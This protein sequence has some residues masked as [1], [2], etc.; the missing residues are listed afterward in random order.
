M[1][2]ARSAEHRLSS[3]K[4]CSIGSNKTK[5]LQAGLNHKID[6]KHSFG[7]I[8]QRRFA[9]IMGKSR[10]HPNCNYNAMVGQAQNPPHTQSQ[11]DNQHLVINLYECVEAI[12]HKD[13]TNR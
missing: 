11:V 4:L 5:Q 2:I 3:I 7:V 6:I 13:T 12:N 10:V 8:K 9:A 1:T